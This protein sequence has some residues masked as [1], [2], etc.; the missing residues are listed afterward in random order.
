MIKYK[1]KRLV[2]RF[3]PFIMRRPGSGR[4]TPP[5]YFHPQAIGETRCVEKI[6]IRVGWKFICNELLNQINRPQA[7]PFNVF[8]KPYSQKFIGW[9]QT[10]QQSGIDQRGLAIPRFAV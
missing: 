2:Y 3:L 5:F 8:S 7:L 10:G 4:I 6:K 9:S 1:Q